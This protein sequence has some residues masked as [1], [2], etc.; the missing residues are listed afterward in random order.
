MAG[1]RDLRVLLAVD[2]SESSKIVTSAVAERFR[3]E[4]TEVCL[5]HVLEVRRTVPTSFAFARG[6]TYGK[7]LGSIM[8][9]GYEQAADRLARL[10]E[11]LRAEGFLVTVALAEG[12]PLQ[13]ILG[14]AERWEADLIVLGVHDRSWLDLFFKTVAEKVVREASCSVEVVRAPLG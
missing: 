1:S 12:C 4:H 8:K 11:V 7:Q 14:Y 9:R 5:L 10:A 3:P 6:R 13:V 2:N